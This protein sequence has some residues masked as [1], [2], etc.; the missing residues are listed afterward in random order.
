MRARS[1]QNV[2]RATEWVFDI[3]SLPFFLMAMDCEYCIVWIFKLV[4]TNRNFVFPFS[5]HSLA[6]HHTKLDDSRISFETPSKADA[7]AKFFLLHLLNF[8]RWFYA[9]SGS[10]ELGAL[11][12]P[13]L[14]LAGWCWWMADESTEKSEKKWAKKFNQHTKCQTQH[15][16]GETRRLS[17]TVVKE[18]N[19]KNKNKSSNEILVFFTCSFAAPNNFN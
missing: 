7:P 15:L 17:I 6:R 14:V 1:M 11:F 9:F 2:M 19:E 12:F 16:I 10:A 5:L 3:I 18:S 8:V 13:P 4:S